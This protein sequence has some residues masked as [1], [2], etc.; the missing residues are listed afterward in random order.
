MSHLDAEIFQHRRSKAD[1]HFGDRRRQLMCRKCSTRIRVVRYYDM[2]RH[3][4][5][6]LFLDF[7]CLAPSAS[8]ALSAQVRFHGSAC[9]ASTVP[10]LRHLHGGMHLTQPHSST[11]L[12]ALACN[13]A[14]LQR[15]FAL[16]RRPLRPCCCQVLVAG[17]SAVVSK[18]MLLAT[19]L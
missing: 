15:V 18:W 12:L 1:Q 5:L 8:V 2:L 10:D 6:Y 16:L 11:D 3:C 13:V 14:I 7:A 9:I 19:T 17:D 4:R